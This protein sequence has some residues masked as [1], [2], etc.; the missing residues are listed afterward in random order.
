MRLER[1]RL[2]KG[3]LG[4]LRGAPPGPRRR[5]PGAG[6]RIRQAPVEP[7][8]NPGAQGRGGPARRH[9]RGRREQR[10]PAAGCSHGKTRWGAAAGAAGEGRRAP[11][12]HATLT[13]RPGRGCSV[14]S[15]GALL[16]GE[17]G[18]PG[19]QKMPG[20]AGRP[21]DREPVTPLLRC[22]APACP[23][24]TSH[25]LGCEGEGGPGWYTPDTR[26][27]AHGHL[28]ATAASGDQPGGGAHR[29]RQWRGRVCGG[30]H[31]PAH[32]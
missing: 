18:G 23:P 2:A 31:A 16:A 26:G 14:P 20:G 3:D 9:C 6:R 21:G 28:A 25:A 27:A 30:A 24:C 17:G 4:V 1:A 11:G 8:K 32:T 29:R 15:P 10:R 22:C 19:K 12:S 5:R 7:W 13:G